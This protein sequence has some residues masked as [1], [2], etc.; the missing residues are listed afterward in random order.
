MKWKKSPKNVVQHSNV[1]LKLDIWLKRTVSPAPVTTPSSDGAAVAF[2][3]AFVWLFETLPSSAKLASWR[4]GSSQPVHQSWRHSLKVLRANWETVKPRVI[5]PKQRA[6]ICFSSR[7]E[8]MMG[9]V[10]PE[11]SI[12]SHIDQCEVLLTNWAEGSI[13]KYS[14]WRIGQSGP[15]HGK[16]AGRWG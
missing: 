10:T 7:A 12:T 9:T 1:Y 2:I 11:T 14:W 15:F 4:A 3:W 8:G 13:V 6:E 16:G 5:K